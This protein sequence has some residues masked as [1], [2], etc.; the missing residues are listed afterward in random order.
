MSTNI[1]VTIPVHCSDAILNV[2]YN[3]INNIIYV[4]DK[5]KTNKIE[6]NYMHV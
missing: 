5:I 4:K 6:Y 1:S 2:P 3:K